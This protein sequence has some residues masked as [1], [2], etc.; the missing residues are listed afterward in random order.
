M[1]EYPGITLT[2]SLEPGSENRAIA[3][4]NAYFA[5]LSGV[6]SGYTGGRFD[7]FDPSGTRD[8]SV[9]V[10]TADDVVSVSLLSV[11]VDGRS[12]I[13]LL[14]RQRPRFSALLAEVGPDL[15]LVEVE[16]TEPDRFPARALY[17]ALRDLPN[18]GPTTASKLLARKRPRLIPIYDSVI[19]EHVLGGRRTLWEPLRR[20]L[21]ADHRW[22]QR[23]LLELRAAAGLGEHISPLRVFD[24]LAWM[25]GSGNA[26]RAIRPGQQ[27]LVKGRPAT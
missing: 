16:S 5:P 15:D 13:E 19:N 7:D 1:Q 12:A 22:L 18:V 24:V 4:L 10:F 11:D 2:A 9:N 26:E 17:R 3:A 27:P 14:D 8:A 21:R 6:N 23:H 20:A 25:D